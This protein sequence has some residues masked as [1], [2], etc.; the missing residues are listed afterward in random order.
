[1]KGRIIYN[2]ND[3]SSDVED[4][5][6]QILQTDRTFFKSLEYKVFKN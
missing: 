6:H 1:M 5:I 3:F 2:T 4:K